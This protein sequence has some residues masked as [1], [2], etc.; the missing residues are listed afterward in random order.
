MAEEPQS[1]KPDEAF[2]A[3]AALK[4]ALRGYAAVAVAGAVWFIP[5]GSGFL[6][7]LA[8]VGTPPPSTSPSWP[9]RSRASGRATS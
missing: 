5:A 1:G 7:F 9:F 8:V 3:R 2:E 6:R 4:L